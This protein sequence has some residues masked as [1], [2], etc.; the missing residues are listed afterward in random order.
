MNWLPYQQPLP[1]GRRRSA[2]A[3][4]G[5]VVAKRGG[6]KT[7][8]AGYLVA[9]ALTPGDPLF[10]PGGEI[11]LFAGSIE[12]CRLT[13]RQALG[14]LEDRLSDYRTVDSATR[15][16]ITHKASRT[17]LKAVGSNP[18]TS[19]GLVGVP[20]A[21]I[22]EPAALHTIG[23]QALWDSVRTAQGKV[24]S[25]LRILATGTLAP[26]AEGSWWHRLVEAG[27]TGSTCVQLLQ[28]RLDR[29]DHWREIVRVNP[30]ARD[31]AEL[32]D[33]LRE[34]RDAARADGRLKSSFLSMRLNLPS[35]DESTT[36]LLTV[37]D[38][39]RMAERPVPA[40]TGRPIFAYDLGGGSAHGLPPS[41]SGGAA[42]S[43]A[44]A[45]APG[46]PTLEAQ[47]RRDRVPAGLYRAL[48][49]TGAPERCRGFA[50]PTTRRAPRRSTGRVGASTGNSCATDSATRSCKTW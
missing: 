16:A 50:R 24:G 45:V 2:L 42:A 43:S 39:E 35:A 23:G 10:V 13:Y 37:D 1:E 17:R 4:G 19:L 6:G 26:A 20:L 34:E 12:Q 18:K 33:V 40:R 44:L 31:H 49:Q 22:D 27:T 38:W 25:P 36:V 46:V 5:R 41:R 14:F 9:R 3:D 48:A 21:I 29:W 15:V 28:G 30:L 7:T 11:V 47:E 8:C 32:A